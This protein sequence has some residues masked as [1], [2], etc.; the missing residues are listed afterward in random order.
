V[1]LFPVFHHP[2]LNTPASLY[3]TEDPSEGVTY[4]FIGT[5]ARNIVKAGT[6]HWVTIAIQNTQKSPALWGNGHMITWNI[7]I[8]HD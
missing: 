1:L 3:G 7:G 2:S 5:A 4:I 6:R 8:G